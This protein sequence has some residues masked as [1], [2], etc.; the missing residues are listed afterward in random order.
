VARITLSDIAA[1]A[2]VNVGTVSRVL[3]GK[4]K[5]GRISEELAGRIRALAD[6]L[7][8]LPNT[9]ARA[10]QTGRFNAV[11]LVMST[12]EHRSYFPSGLLNGI[13]D[14]LA[15]R[16][17]QLQIVK[18]PDDAFADPAKTPA[19]FRTRCVDGLLVNY[20][21]RV[22]DALVRAL[23]SY[24]VPTIWL[25]V[26]QK[27]DAVYT[28]N[29]GAGQE[30]TQRLL[31]LGHCRIAYLSTGWSKPD[32]A[33]LA[34]AHYSVRD[35]LSGYLRAME[36]AELPPLVFA[37]EREQPSFETLQQLITTWMVREKPSAIIGYWITSFAP[38][39]RVLWRTRTRV[40][41]DVSLCCFAGESMP[42][43]ALRISGLVEPE[44]D[45]GCRAVE[46]LTQKIRS[47]R[48]S[49]PSE[50]LLMHWIDFGT[51]LQCV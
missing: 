5:T 36:K 17:L 14:A 34:D 45:L 19:L 29:L 2:G 4:D 24:G 41:E 23:E 18:V 50:R 6:R 47:R 48:K 20:T 13:Y 7:G 21:H 46:L 28:D 1:K 16:G 44:Y 26:R 42:G 33:L 43:G 39:V 37:H 32:V 51:C 8:Y 12:S 27:N 25:N 11:A 40:P 3:N 35:R 15:Q 9:S 49:L 30:L 31:A 22:P 10:M 38:L